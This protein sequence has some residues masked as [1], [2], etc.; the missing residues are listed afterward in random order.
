[1]D[2]PFVEMPKYVTD[3]I[4]ADIN[5][6][7]EAFNWSDKDITWPVLLVQKTN[8]SKASM[9][10]SSTGGRVGRWQV[11]LRLHRIQRY[12]WT[13]RKTQPWKGTAGESDH[14]RSHWSRRQLEKIIISIK[15]INL[16][17]LVNS[18]T[19]EFSQVELNLTS[20][21]TY[22]LWNHGQ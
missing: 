8:L 1:M 6:W 10:P 9:D 22:S 21:R 19:C 18:V 15:Q 4:D 13:D 3:I 16:A 20:V 5:K 7:L 12:K 14:L 17:E 11:L 2:M